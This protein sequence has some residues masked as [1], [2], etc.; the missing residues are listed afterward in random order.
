MKLNLLVFSLAGSGYLKID[1]YFVPG[2]TVGKRRSGQRVLLFLGLFFFLIFELF[3]SLDE[4]EF[5]EI[6]ELFLLTDLSSLNWTDSIAMFGC[7]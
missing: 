2:G 1:W 6:V 5:F 7:S 3:V 4:R